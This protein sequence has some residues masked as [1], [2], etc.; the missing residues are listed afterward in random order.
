MSEPVFEFEVF[1]D[2]NGDG[3]ILTPFGIRLFVITVGTIK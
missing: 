2:T 1:S 3:R